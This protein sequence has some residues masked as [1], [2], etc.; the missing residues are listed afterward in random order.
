MIMK[1]LTA[2]LAV[3]LTVLAGQAMAQSAVETQQPERAAQQSP[4]TSRQDS[5][6]SPRERQPLTTPGASARTQ[7]AGQLDQQIAT[8]LILGNQQEI[9]LAQ[10][11]QER[12]EN[13]QVKQFAQTMI[14]QHQQALSK[15]QQAAPQ[16]AALNLKLHAKQGNRAQTEAE[17]TESG[18]QPTASTQ[19]ASAEARSATAS[20]QGGAEHQMAQFAREVKQECLNLVTAELGQQQGAEFDK[21]YLGQQ[22]GAHLGMLAELRVSQRHAS[23]QL[24]PVLQEG[25]QMTEQH[26]AQA[27]SI[28]EQLHSASGSPPQ[29]A[30]RAAPTQPPK[31]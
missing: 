10:F 28:M 13:P 1:K 2:P 31:R 4:A 24:K 26:L 20:A 19:P 16:V 14:E 15:L 18:V 30:R 17:S 22:I 12:A 9:A 29:A 25:E 6:T 11:A 7:G 23:Q 5:A 21:A 8:C 3:A 27:K